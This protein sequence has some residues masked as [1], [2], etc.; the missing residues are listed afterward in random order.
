MESEDTFQ[1]LPELFAMIAG[2]ME[3]SSHN[4]RVSAS[5]CLISFMANCVP[6]QVILE[7]SIY[8]EKILDKI[9]KVA[10]S[11]L[12]V[13]FQAAWMESFNV[14]GA[15]FDALRWRANPMLLSVA[16][17]VGDI[18]GNDSFMGKKEADEVI[19]KAIRAMGPEAVLSVL[20]LNLSKPVKGEPGRAWMLPILRDYITNT[21][22]EHF[23][24]EFVPLSQ[25]MFQKVLDN[26]AAAKTMEIKIYE[27][28]VHQ[29]WSLL[30]GYCDLPLDLTT[31]FDQ[32]FAEMLANL[33]YQQVDLRLDICR[34]LKALVES[35][36]AVAGLD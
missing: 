21:N 3:S 4:I 9:A 24:T 1:N 13:K 18:R 36:Q 7:P 32:T 26:G 16:K 31:A 11:F 27:T 34:G 29:I 30:P 15:M 28:L 14:L 33:L 25:A 2:F 17:N 6:D 8:D 12:S 22:L 20:P 35:N 23:K 19:G 10:E 5:E